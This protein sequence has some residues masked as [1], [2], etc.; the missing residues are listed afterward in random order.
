MRHERTLFETLI[1]RGGP[2]KGGRQASFVVMWA[3]TAHRLG[4][5]PMQTEVRAEWRLSERTCHRYVHEFRKLFPEFGDVA[6]PQVFVPAMEAAVADRLTRKT[7]RADASMLLRV[8]APSLV[9]G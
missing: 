6:T 4:R 8:A 2:L 5:E 3:M 9:S 7:P 1:E